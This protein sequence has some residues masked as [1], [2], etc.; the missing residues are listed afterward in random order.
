MGQSLQVLK[1]GDEVLAGLCRIKGQDEPSFL[2]KIK[3]QSYA[4][5]MAAARDFLVILQELSRMG[6]RENQVAAV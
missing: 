1:Q 4:L 5:P 3:G 2:M 6:T